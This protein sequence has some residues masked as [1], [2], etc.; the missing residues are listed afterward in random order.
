MWI[1]A[2]P[3]PKGKQASDC[4]I[5]A[6]CIALNQ[7]WYQVFDELCFTAREDCD[8]PS[9]D[10]VWG[11]LLYLK[12]FEPFSLPEYCP[13]CITIKEFARQFP[14]GI[15]II[16]TG[17]HAVCVIDGDYYDSWDSGD[18]IP[19]FFWKIRNR[20]DIYGVF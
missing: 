1:R 9:V 3:N 14:F 18:E 19:S 5:R 7:S 16:G 20:S 10:A 12:G 15:Y 13:R 6:I 17:Y 4:V 2:N 8:M 11:H